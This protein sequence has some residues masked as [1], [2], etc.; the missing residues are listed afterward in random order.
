MIFTAT[1]YTRPER[2]DD[3]AELFGAF[4]QPSREEPG[5]IEYHM[6][7]DQA[8]P[9]I[10]TFFE[11]WRSEADLEVHKALAH[12]QTFHE[13]RMEYLLRDFEI[14]QFDAVVKGPHS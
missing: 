5:C 8:D 2:A 7:R 9:S 11:I 10:F 3:F 13:N 6:L 4:V 12:M 14:R 1:A